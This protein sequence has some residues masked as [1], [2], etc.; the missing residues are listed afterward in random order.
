MTGLDGGTV[1]VSLYIKNETEGR[2][3]MM[4]TDKHIVL[5]DL[6]KELTSVIEDQDKL[7]RRRSALEKLVTGYREL[8]SL[9]GGS[10][11]APSPAIASGTITRTTFAK[12]GIAEG[13]IK[14]LQLVGKNQTNRQITDALVQGGKK[15]TSGRF[16][17]TVRTTLIHHAERPSSPLH[18]TGKDWELKEWDDRPALALPLED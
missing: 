3:K 17:D 6:E 11:P 12:L 16:A 13:A 2:T 1:A 4:E 5:A 10:A 9:N 18:W 15:S 14:Y 8:I 7:A